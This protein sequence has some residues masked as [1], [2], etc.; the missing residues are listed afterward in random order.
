MRFNNYLNEIEL[1]SK[2]W[3]TVKL[4]DLD[5]DVL[6]VLWKMYVNTY[7]KEGLDLS[8]NGPNELQG[9]YEATWL[10]DIDKDDNPDAFIIYRKTKHGNKIALLGTDGQKE[11]KNVLVKKFTSLLKSKGWVIEASKKMEEICKKS[12]LNVVDNE[13]LVREILGPK[14]QVEWLEDGYYNRS[15]SLS[16]KLIKKRM[17]GNAK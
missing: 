10:I 4:S 11:S 1:P 12:G 17:Y 15:L 14:K 8:A 2:K 3:V 13:L 16:G 7:K 5:S 9:K 6:D